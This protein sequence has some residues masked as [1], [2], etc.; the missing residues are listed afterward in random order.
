MS[1]MRM[2]TQKNHLLNPTDLIGLI[3]S[4][5]PKDGPIPLHE[6]QLGQ[7]EQS[8]AQDCIKSTFVSS[9]GP[10][11]NQFEKKIES[12]TGSEACVATTNGTVALMT[13]LKLIGASSG[14]EVITQALTFVATANAISH[15]G[16]CPVFVDNDPNNFGL[17]PDS[18]QAFLKEN[19]EMRKNGPVNR[20]TGRDVIACIPVHLWGHPC[21]IDEIVQICADYEIP[22]I[23]DA[24]ESLGSY[25]KGKHSGTFGL[26]GVFS[27]NGN[28]IVTSGGG[29]AIITNNIELSKRAKHLTTTA[30]V[31]HPWAYVHDEIG[32]NY[33]LPNINA[34]LGC[35]QLKRLEEF[36][37]IKR[38][39]AK[40]YG[41][42]IEKLGGLFLWEPKNSKSNYWLNSLILNSAQERDE[43]LTQLH[44]AK[45]YCRPAWVPLT[46]LPIYRSC[47]SMPLPNMKFISDRVLNLPSSAIE[48]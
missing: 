9:I 28:K 20:L 44:Q 37:R 15:T 46:D 23:E 41:E 43:F 47:F 10:Y 16:A 35:A 30:K 2:I 1:K 33:R 4:I 8:Y 19:V 27:F 36:I 18:L 39:I 48:L 29:G 21:R 6:P 31:P 5:Y 32:Y 11:V 24:A 42:A 7:L 26:M 45:I 12:I 14:T 17:N 38:I 40:M 13:A 3:R 22:V 25:Y 34:A